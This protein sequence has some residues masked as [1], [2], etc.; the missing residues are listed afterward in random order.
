MGT[1]ESQP[2][3]LIDHLGKDWVSPERVQ[4]KAIHLCDWKVWSLTPPLLD[5]I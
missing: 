3:P 4:V 2:E 1:V 5:L